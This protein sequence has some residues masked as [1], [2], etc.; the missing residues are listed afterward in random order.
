MADG[1]M[2]RCL[3]RDR[4]NVGFTVSE[5]EVEKPFPLHWHSYIELELI[6]AGS[7]HQILNGQR[8][9][10]SRGCLSLLRPTDFHQVEPEKGLQLFNMSIDDSLLSEELLRKITARSMIFLQM[11]ED[12]TGTMER[13]LHLSL[14]ENGLLSPNQEYQKHLLMCILL[15]VLHLVPGTT[16]AASAESRPIQAALLYLHMHFR[17]NPRLSDV[18]EIAHYN[19]SYFSAA[20]HGEVGMTYSEYLNM[21][22]IAYAR[23]LL[24]STGL[25]V[26]E[27]CCECGFT[28][29]SGFL[30]LF[31]KQT[32]LSPMQFR[33]GEEGKE[34]YCGSV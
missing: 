20:F 5:R 15:R 8:F 3:L 16:R 7:G 31:R 12:E 33:K 23:E 22:K 18:A 19:A 13:L 24:L 29:Y 2:Y 21:L 14:E 1:K 17:E 28:S 25:K 34:E 4:Q 26:S 11:D 10:L 6:T 9:E 30:T 32:G 27:V